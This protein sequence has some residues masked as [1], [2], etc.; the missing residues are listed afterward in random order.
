MGVAAQAGVGQA[1]I[2]GVNLVAAPQ[3]LRDVDGFV[4]QPVSEIAVAVWAA[5][6]RDGIDPKFTKRPLGH[7]RALPHVFSGCPNNLIE[8]HLGFFGELYR[9]LTVVLVV[10]AAL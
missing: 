2:A 8:R 1:T 3:R 10:S 7:V 6:V 5:A 9:L 4:A